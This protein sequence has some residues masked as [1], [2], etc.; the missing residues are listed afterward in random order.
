MKMKNYI[1]DNT[2]R[3]GNHTIDNRFSEDDIF[4]ICKSLDKAKVDF[5]EIGYALGLNSYNKSDKPSDLSLFKIAN[6][7]VSYSKILLFAFPNNIDYENIK[8]L[9]E[10]GAEFIRIAVDSRNINKTKEVIKS[11]VEL[12][13][14]TGAFFTMAHKY[15]TEDLIEISKKLYDLGV[16]S[17][18]ITDSAGTMMPNEV[19][20]I[21]ESLKNNFDIPVGFH[22]HDNLGLAVANSLSALDSNASFIDCAL[23]GLGAGAGNTNTEALAAINEKCGYGFNIDF[24]G[25]IEASKLL[26]SIIKNYGI[27]KDAIEENI[28]V[29]YYGIYSAL[30]KYAK[31]L[32][33]EL[34]ISYVEIVKLIAVNSFSPNDKEKIRDASIKLIN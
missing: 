23:S 15:N 10:N 32:S 16:N 6:S 5:I 13:Y 19:S 8:L 18:T 31:E 17:F 2:L 14:K 25:T 27:D 21:V 22:G 4:R 12:G 30:I 29:G 28:I 1:V 3:D 33:K 20:N 34:G 9:R 11:C 7:A 26:R 24:F